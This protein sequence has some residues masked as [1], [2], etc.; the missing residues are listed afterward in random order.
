MTVA[1]ILLLHDNSTI[2]QTW[3]QRLLQS[4]FSA[5]PA[6][7]TNANA[8]EILLSSPCILICG[9]S[10]NDGKWSFELIQQ[11]RQL[12][13]KLPIIFV[14]TRGSE[15]LAVRALRAGVTDY[16]SEPQRVDE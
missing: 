1:K 14:A 5:T 8:R 7:L 9:D 3:T 2:R 13:P 12:S 10:G 11:L 6:T 15:D 4:G 16:V